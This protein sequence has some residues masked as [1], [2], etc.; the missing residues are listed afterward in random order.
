MPSEFQNIL[1][2]VVPPPWYHILGFSEGLVSPPVPKV[3]PCTVLVLQITGFF[4]LLTTNGLTLRLRFCRD[5]LMDPISWF[6]WCFFTQPQI[7]QEGIPSFLRHYLKINKEI[8]RYFLVI[9][10][11]HSSWGYCSSCGSCSSTHGLPH[12][13]LEG[14]S[15]DTVHWIHW[16]S[17]P[18]LSEIT[19]SLKS[20]LYS[21]FDV[22]PVS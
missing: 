7:F 13:V 15:L 3:M 4:T 5:W 1:W 17:A 19:F 6:I 18:S 8:H 11:Y 14:Q 22:L 12:L 9:W 16:I 10:S 20:R 21:N 2:K